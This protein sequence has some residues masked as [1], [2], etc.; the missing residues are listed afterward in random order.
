MQHKSSICP[1]S[2]SRSFSPLV[3]TCFQAWLTVLNWKV[4]R[5]AGSYCCIVCMGIHIVFFEKEYYFFTLF[6]NVHYPHGEFLRT[7]WFQTLISPEIDYVFRC[8]K[9]MIN[10]ISDN[11]WK[12]EKQFK[13]SHPCLTSCQLTKCGLATPCGDIYLSQNWLR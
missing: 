3:E 6:N 11:F 7:L 5:G 8:G 13:R 4:L 9:L 12:D 1:T 10:S 2:H